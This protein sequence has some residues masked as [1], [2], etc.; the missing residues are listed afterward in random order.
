MTLVFGAKHRNRKE[1]WITADDE[2][3][4]DLS[5]ELCAT[6]ATDEGKG[7]GW[8]HF[9][10]VKGHFGFIKGINEYETMKEI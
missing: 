9:F 2:V 3:N 10:I 7:I 4:G 1:S 6:D 5:L 8:V